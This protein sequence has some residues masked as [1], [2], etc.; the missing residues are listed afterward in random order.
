V[1]CG[2]SQTG[3]GRLRSMKVL[4]IIA[5][6]NTGGPARHVVILNRGLRERGYET[7]LV[8]GHVDVGEGSLEYLAEEAGVRQVR[9]EEL[10]R[11]V[12]PFDDC[13]A[14]IKLV[15]LVFCEAPD[16]IHTHTAK[17][18]ALGRIA[19]LAFNVTRSRRHRSLVVHTF[20][21]HVF[22]NY[23][24]PV[25]NCLIRVAERA[26]STVTDRVVTIAP[27]QKRD[28]VGRFRI[29]PESRTVVIPLG[30]DLQP[31]LALSRNHPTLRSQL[32]INE[33]QVVI[34]FIGRFVPIKDL[35]T[36]MRAF[37]ILATAVPNTVL[38][39]AGDGPVRSELTELCQRLGVERRTRFL[40][41][42]TDLTTLFATLDICVLSSLNEGTPIAVIEAMAAATPVVATDVGGVADVI[43]HGVTGLL[44][45]P[46][47]PEALAHSLE[48][49]ARDPSARQRMGQVARLSAA[50]R[51]TS[52]R[53]VV[54]TDHMYMTALVEKRGRGAT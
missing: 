20:H 14:L 51:F 3:T 13:K 34:G 52:D 12:R 7:V 38:L 49:L 28:I 17:A 25:A 22:T 23:F 8:H 50:Q 33:G 18:G 31:L 27:S 15:R 41:W 54:D 30:L 42:S 36:L 35:P 48:T 1:D 26:L 46:R 6:L 10:G 32:G 29:A 47:N 53:L 19:A 5:R 45:P 24:G 37:A 43:E 40:G 21:G 39:L 9:V 16:I 11:R 4:R 44:V 2:W